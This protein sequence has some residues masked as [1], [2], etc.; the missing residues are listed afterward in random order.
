VSRRLGLVIGNSLYRDS[1]LARLTAPDVDVGDF[2]DV[3]LN[4]EIGG[5]DDVDVLVNSSSFI[6]R[7]AISEFFS[8]KDR[9]DLL[10]LYFSGHGVLDDQ[11]RLY[12]AVKDTERTLLRA[13]S[14]PAYFITDEMNNSRSQ[15]QVLILDCCHSGAFAR[16]TKG[17]PGATVGTATAFEGTG[18]G[19]VV[20]TATDATQYAWEGDQ[21][22]GTAESSVFTKYLVKGLGSGEADLDKNG[23]VTI[24]ELFDYVEQQVLI[25]TPKQ[26][27]GKWSYKQQGEIII[28]RNPYRSAESEEVLPVSEVEKPR[29]E[30]EEIEKK[31]LPAEVEKSP[32]RKNIAWGWIIF[33]LVLIGII[34]FLLSK[35]FA[36]SNPAVQ[37]N[38]PTPSAA[39][40]VIDINAAILTLTAQAIQS[41][42]QEPTRPVIQA[43]TAP[44]PSKASS[45]IK[46]S[47]LIPTKTPQPTQSFMAVISVQSANVRSGPGVIYPVVAAMANGMQLSA[48]GKNNDGSWLVVKLPDGR[49]AWI[50][51][52]VVDINFNTRDL[53]VINAPPTPTSPPPTPTKKPKPPS[54]GA[55]VFVPPALD[56]ENPVTPINQR[57]QVYSLLTTTL[58]LILLLVLEKRKVKRQFQILKRISMAILS[59]VF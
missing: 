12:M 39:E 32:P 16:G 57:K 24:D 6:V 42:P 1:T 28:A 40:K 15:R 27:P 13:T 31:I 4:P 25:D 8:G 46:T 52:S 45:I 49:Q 47:T 48:T 35:V 53:P 33:S 14:I 26:T 2:A 51:L 29:T 20:L 59:E 3:L 17:V 21:I 44:Q 43:T 55:A 41:I 34:G 38:T 50:A 54:Y 7:R 9:D 56:G 5:F 36:P 11:G 10:L 58:F 22:V 18:Y 19:R 37:S 30:K 23:K